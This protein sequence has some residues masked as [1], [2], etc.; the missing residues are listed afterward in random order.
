M[1]TF[2]HVTGP[3][4]FLPRCA[5][6]DVSLQQGKARENNSTADLWETSEKPGGTEV[7]MRRRMVTAREEALREP[8][9]AIPSC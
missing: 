2:P 8:I 6:C 3:A 7:A 5:P 1:A 9:W 4:Q